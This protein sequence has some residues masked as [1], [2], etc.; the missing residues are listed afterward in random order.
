MSTGALA[1]LIQA[2]AE[3]DPG[4]AEAGPSFK[5]LSAADVR[6]MPP[7]RWRLHGLVPERGCGAI[8]GPWGTG[9][10]FLSLDMAAALQEGRDWFGH[11]NR[12]AC[13]VV[14]VVLEGH[15]GVPARIRAWEDVNGRP[16]PPVRF[17]F[18]AL[19]L[20]DR[21]HVLGLAAAIEA[22][23]GADGVITDT[24]AR[25]TPG[26][27]ENSPQDAGRIIDAIDELRA[28][29]GGFHA[30]VHHAGKN[31]QAGL[32]GHSSIGGA[33]DFVI[34]TE[35]RENPR[36]WSVEKM[37]DGAEGE[38]HTYTLQS[39]EV[40]QD[41]EGHAIT[42]CAV[43]AAALDIAP[44]PELVKPRGGNQ[45]IVYDALLPLFK[46]SRDFGRAGAPSA[47][48]CITLDA[49]IDAT[50]DR[51]AVEPKRRTERVRQAVTGLLATRALR[52][53]EGWLWLP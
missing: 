40:G 11:R 12:G 27:D 39:V 36:R 4:P 44:E 18:D 13:R 35:G 5:L 48:P 52:G 33:L 20:L 49:A 31:I 28:L 6:A 16:F 25:A 2:A 10:S 19:R 14:Y 9:K 30:V 34:A 41:E 47:R 26:A 38:A 21:G 46:A 15:G 17:V 22:D 32:R 42:S 43:V 45:K 23:G 50:R 3:D 8:Y 1:E 7:T 29:V 51:L 53:N 24:L 37:K